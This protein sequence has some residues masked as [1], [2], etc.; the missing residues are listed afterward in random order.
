MPTSTLTEENSLGFCQA[1]DGDMHEL[2]PTNGLSVAIFTAVRIAKPKKN[3]LEILEAQQELFN[4]IEP[5]TKWLRIHRCP[6]WFTIFT[7]WRYW[8][9]KIRA[10]GG[11]A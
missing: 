8:A 4:A 11:Q 2:C 5:P 1:D 3:E 9:R 7:Y 10:L 6:S